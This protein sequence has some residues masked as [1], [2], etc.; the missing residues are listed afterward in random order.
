MELNYNDIGTRI[1]KKRIYLKMTQDT[2]AEKVNL[3]TPHMSHIETG[4]TKVSLPT[5]LRIA[6]ELK[7]SMDELLCDSLVHA[8]HQFT[9]EIYQEIIDCSD[10][11]IRIIADTVKA[12][13]KSL[14]KRKSRT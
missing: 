1:K 3:S 9:D 13:K 12:L 2:L 5:L 8:H 7:C 14:R 11:E 6:N 4:N 10:D